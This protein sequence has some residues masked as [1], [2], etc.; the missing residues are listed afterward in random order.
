MPLKRAFAIIAL[1]LAAMTAA[2]TSPQNPPPLETVI[3]PASHIF[4]G[5]VLPATY[6]SRDVCDRDSVPYFQRDFC[7]EAEVQVDVE[8]YL[9]PSSAEPGRVTVVYLPLRT[10]SIKSERSEALLF[11]TVAEERAGPAKFRLSSSQPGFVAPAKLQEVRD[12][13][14]KC[15]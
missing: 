2:A 3:C 9:R 1:E 12:V 6:R 14:R 4:V 15:N 5:H 10:V 8:Q 7:T 13:I 11:L